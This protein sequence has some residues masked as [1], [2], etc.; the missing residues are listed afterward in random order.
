MK[1]GDNT[2]QFIGVGTGTLPSE[3]G[4]EPPSGRL[5]IITVAKNQ[6]S[7]KIEVRRRFNIVCDAP[8]YSLAQ[9]GVR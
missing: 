2:Y 4:G 3:G 7:G 5:L 9:Y 8:V 6:A 1:I